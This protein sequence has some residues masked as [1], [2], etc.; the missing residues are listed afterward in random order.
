MIS[1]NV[2]ELAYIYIYIGLG[3]GTHVGSEK[4]DTYT[5]DRLGQ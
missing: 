1:F 2:V 5:L 3:L 4:R